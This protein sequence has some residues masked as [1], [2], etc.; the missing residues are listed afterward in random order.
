M[1]V[2]NGAPNQVSADSL[3]DFR[4]AEDFTLGSAALLTS[5]QFWDVEG[6][7]AYSGSIAWAIF[8]NAAGTPG[9]ALAQGSASTLLQI[10]RTSTG[11]AC[12][13]SFSE[14][15]DDINLATSLTSGS[16]SL[17]A[18]TYWLVL[19]NGPISSSTFNDFY[20]ET[21]ANNGTTR[22]MYQD[23]TIVSPPWISTLQEHA[24]NISGTFTGVPETGSFGMVGAGLAGLLALGARRF[25]K[26]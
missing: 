16:L 21:T 13:V 23:L 2:N 1:I 11:Q 19:H 18:N 20:W 4:V 17:A 12:C 14:F 9:V 22:G 25:R 5:F 10:T 3:S 7:G 15:L 8:T 26:R 6:G 24:F